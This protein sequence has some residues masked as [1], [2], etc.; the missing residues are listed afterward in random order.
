M[1]QSIG[2]GWLIIA[3]MIIGGAIGASVPPQTSIEVA[4]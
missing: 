2:I 4:A 3:S 1:S